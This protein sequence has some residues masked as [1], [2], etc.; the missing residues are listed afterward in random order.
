[1]HVSNTKRE[2]LCQVVPADG[3]SLLILRF[4]SLKGN[5]SVRLSLVTRYLLKSRYW[6][7]SLRQLVPSDDCSLLKSRQWGINVLSA[8]VWRRSQLANFTSLRGK[9][10][11]QLVHGEEKSF[12]QHMCP[13]R[14]TAERLMLSGD[15]DCQ[16][17]QLL[18]IYCH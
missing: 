12:F 15:K 6:G 14:K 7:E 18:F 17:A 8:S 4:T 3:H 16:I 13:L 9:S 10:F 11:C 5:H 1:M 2:L